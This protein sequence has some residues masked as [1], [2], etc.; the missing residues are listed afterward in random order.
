MKEN[1]TCKKPR[2]SGTLDGKKE[3][4]MHTGCPKWHRYQNF[5]HASR[6]GDEVVSEELLLACN[7]NQLFLNFS[8][9]VKKRSE[10]Q[11][12]TE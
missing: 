11:F 1:Y 5:D 7:K 2:I 12:T 4:R 6:G 9:C 3:I 8:K 10:K